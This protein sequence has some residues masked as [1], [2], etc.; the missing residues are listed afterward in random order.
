MA[1]LPPARVLPS[2]PF[3]HV[4]VDYAGPFLIKEGRRKQARSV[5]GYLALFVCMVIKAVHIEVV[6]DL[7]TDAF[8]AALHRFVS[9]RGL[10]SD[11]YSDCGTN[12]KGANRELQ[13]MFSEPAAQE[14]YS[15]AISCHWHFNPP[16][17]PHFGGL[18]E[19]AVKSCKYHLKRV[20]GTQ[21]L[22]FEEMATLVSRIEAIL[23]SRPITPQSSSP[24]DLNPLTPGHFLVGGPL[25]TIAEPDLTT[26]PMNR[27][28]RWQ[29]LT[30]FHQSFWTR[31]ASEY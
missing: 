5:K 12:F 2:R 13:R 27:L 22:T 14:L 30:L 21:M 10:P 9:R 17:S 16:A 8:I 28:R 24:H 25:V 20:I 3:A 31:W 4:G 11:I 26:T 29:L 19:A 15:G 7:T 18:W 23:N 1:D 6:S